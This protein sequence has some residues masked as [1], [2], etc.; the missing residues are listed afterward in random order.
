[1]DIA[2]L[3]LARVCAPHLFTVLYPTWFLVDIV[4]SR[5]LG[6]PLKIG[7]RHIGFPNALHW[8]DLHHEEVS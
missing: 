1:M 4:A 6:F 2:A 7:T 5:S 8:A 3:L